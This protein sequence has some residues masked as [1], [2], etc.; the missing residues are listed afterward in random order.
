[1]FSIGEHGRDLLLGQ[2]VS[3]DG[4]RPTN[5]TNVIELSEQHAIR[6]LHAA[7]I[8]IMSRIA[9]PL[10]VN[11][12]MYSSSSF[13][14]ASIYITQATPSARPVELIAHNQLASP[15]AAHFTTPPI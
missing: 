11:F 12:G 1:M 5:R 9:L 6:P 10:T 4:R 13:T 7:A 3:L 8:S 14:S 2:R 15:G